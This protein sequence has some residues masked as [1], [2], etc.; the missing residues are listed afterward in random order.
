MIDLSGIYIKEKATI[1]KIPAHVPVES[2]TIGS[3]SQRRT[4][5]IGSCKNLMKV[6]LVCRSVRSVSWAVKKAFTQAKVM[7]DE[8]GLAKVTLKSSFLP[9]ES[10]RRILRG[11]C[12]SIGP[13]SSLFIY[14]YI[15]LEAQAEDNGSSEE[16]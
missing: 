5:G 14:I 2:S 11:Y 6:C 13:K 16:G 1:G 8:H 15:G 4:W 12:R 9:K 7:Y 3:T 10:E